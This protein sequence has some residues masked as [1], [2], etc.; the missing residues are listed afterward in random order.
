MHQ[1][2]Q[3]INENNVETNA[4][5]IKTL[6]KHNKANLNEDLT[7]GIVDASLLRLFWF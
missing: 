6:I 4:P 1:E 3:N 5:G 7:S 2:K